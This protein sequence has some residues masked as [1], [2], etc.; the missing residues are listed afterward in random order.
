LGHPD[1][2]VEQTIVSHVDL[3]T[4]KGSVGGGCFGTIHIELEV[5]LN[6]WNLQYSGKVGFL[7]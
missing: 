1:G 6:L 3:G 4:V 5:F 7:S 2:L